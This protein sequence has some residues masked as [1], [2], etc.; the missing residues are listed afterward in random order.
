MAEELK[1]AYEGITSMIELKADA[2]EITGQISSLASE[3]AEHRESIATKADATE[4]LERHESHVAE[5]ATSMTSLRE[6]SE[7]LSISINSVQ[8]QVAHVASSAA[9]K[10]ERHEVD[11]ILRMNEA[12]QEQV[13]S[14]KAELQGTLK[15]LETWILEQN[16]R[17]NH[18]MKLQV[19]AAPR[20]VVPLPHPAAAVP[21]RSTTTAPRVFTSS[22]CT[23]PPQP[24]PAKR[25]ESVAGSHASEPTE[26]K[27][28]KPPTKEAP[29]DSAPIAPSAPVVGGVSEAVH[30]KLQKRVE[31]R[32]PPSPRARQPRL[33]STNSLAH[34]RLECIVI[35]ESLMP[36][37]ASDT[38]NSAG[39]GAHSARHA[40]AARAEDAQPLRY[41]RRRLRGAATARAAVKDRRLWHDALPAGRADASTLRRR[42]HASAWLLPAQAAARRRDGSDHELLERP[43]GQACAV[44]WRGGWEWAAVPLADGAAAVATP[45][46][47]ALACRDASR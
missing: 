33:H 3:I 34:L 11:E 22:V 20:P 29:P 42:T 40:A 4:V 37:T 12:V 45:G 18:A 46:K 6:A 43:G 30:L 19:R 27:E 32:T 26:K 23:P 15:A 17:K 1:A 28:E 21:L 13:A 47:A 35:A 2:A 24:K 14:L 7:H 31:V 38:L 9:T 5:A 16:T 39:V 41:G 44:G 8:E 36:L 25:T 10:A